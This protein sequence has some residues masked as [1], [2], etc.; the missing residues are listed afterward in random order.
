MNHICLVTASIK[1]ILTIHSIACSYF[2][3]VHRHVGY[4]LT[5]AFLLFLSVVDLD[6]DGIRPDLLEQSILEHYPKNGFEPSDEKPFWA[7]VYLVPVFHNP[8]SACL[9]EGKV[10]AAHITVTAIE[11]VSKSICIF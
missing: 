9:S 5:Q 10:F 1:D 2:K 8:T 11:N 3:G 6:Q 7:M 4:L